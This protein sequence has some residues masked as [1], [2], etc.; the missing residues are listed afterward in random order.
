MATKETLLEA[1][2]ITSSS[3][4]INQCLL[5]NSFAVSV[6]RTGG[7]EAESLVQNEGL[8]DRLDGRKTDDWWE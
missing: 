1:H 5:L 2:K 4:D 7:Q 6:R 3:G 8:T